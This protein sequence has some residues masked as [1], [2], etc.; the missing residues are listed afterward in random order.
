MLGFSSLDSLGEFLL[1]SKP[2]CHWDTNCQQLLGLLECNYPGERGGLGANLC[3]KGFESL[4]FLVLK[5]T[6]QL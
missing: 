4:G 1:S 2:K 3:V 5:K 6:W